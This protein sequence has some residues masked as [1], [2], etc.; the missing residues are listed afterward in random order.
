[1]T[2]GFLVASALT[3]LAMVSCSS[4][5]H[6]RSH[7]EGAA[8]TADAS[9]G[10]SG[11]QAAAGRTSGARGG[12]APISGGGPGAGEAGASGTPSSRGSSHTGGTPSPG[13][14][15]SPGGMDSTAGAGSPGEAGSGASD[16][17]RAGEPAFP[18]GRKSAAGAGGREPVAGASG[19]LVG[20]AGGAAGQESDRDADGVRD[21]EDNCPVTKNPD[22][23][24]SNVNSVGDVCEA[25]GGF[26]PRF[27]VLAYQPE[28]A[29]EG[30][31]ILSVLGGLTTFE[32]PA[33]AD[34]GYL[35]ALPVAPN[36]A[37][38]SQL[39]PVWVYSDFSNG[40][41]SDVGLLPNGHPFAIRGAHVGDRASELDP[42]S[43]EAVWTYDEVMV[44]H[45]F[46]PLPD[47]GYIFIY[48]TLLEHD[49]YGVD[50]DGDG[51]LEVRMDGVRVID[52]NRNTVWDW[53]LLDHDIDLQAPPSPT[54]STLSDYW[55]NCNS[56]SFVPDPDWTTSDPLR[57]DVYLNCR[58]MNRL[59]D[60]AYPEGNIE[61]VMGRGGDFGSG[62]FHHAHDPS[63][64]YVESGGV[65]VATRILLYDNREAPPLGEADPCPPDETCPGDIEPY[66]R[67]LEVEVD[68]SL[69]AEI[70]WKWPSPTSSD[71]E[72][73]KT[74]S[75]LA[76]GA[77]RLPNGHVLITHATEG[78]NPYLGEVCNTRITEVMPTGS[79]TGGDVV[80][81]VRSD[82]GY[83]S[84][85]ATRFVSDLEGWASHV[86]PPAP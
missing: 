77:Q 34:F 39:L 9:G 15:G 24:D 71:F 32:D 42:V 8:G 60:I 50:V 64:T 47:G 78:G 31:T 82:P 54:Y 3:V 86:E 2:R 52:Q 58:L 6:T 44:N 70:V 27:E 40:A 45:S 19:T 74:Y 29:T 37:T 5:E 67:V 41:F 13:A 21:S 83:C 61:W 26:D 66:S 17:G 53:A 20:G 79:L 68:S 35:A 56:V 30:V 65:R 22:Q 23:Q 59:Y 36:G 69:N 62:F 1:M 72:A 84:F 25:I 49:T 48:S 12:D 76:G 38:V 4:D 11:N 18:G 7:P 16:G 10:T 81:D 80:W 43:G 73:V 46:K 28:H 51:I 14:A 85:K 55:S 33:Y 75:P 63:I 57:G